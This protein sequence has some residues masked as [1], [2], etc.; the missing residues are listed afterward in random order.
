MV[1]RYEMVE[2]PE[3]MEI[4]DDG[5]YHPDLSTSS[6]RTESFRTLEPIIPGPV[7]LRTIFYSPRWTNFQKKA[8]IGMNDVFK[9]EN[10]QLYVLIKYLPIYR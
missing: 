9:I 6:S 5:V 10:R 1:G 3:S 8:C 2:E 7:T 4:I